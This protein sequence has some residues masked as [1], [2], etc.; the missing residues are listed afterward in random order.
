MVPTFALADHTTPILHPQIL[1]RPCPK[2]R[3][4]TE[5]QEDQE[6]SFS[7][8]TGQADHTTLSSNTLR[9]RSARSALWGG[10]DRGEMTPSGQGRH[11]PTLDPSGGSLAAGPSAPGA[12]FSPGARGTR[13]TNFTPARP[14]G[15]VSP[16]GLCCLLC[17]Q[18]QE[19]QG[20]SISLDGENCNCQS[21]ADSGAFLR[22]QSGPPH[23]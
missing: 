7:S 21:P 9:S 16:G 4:L 11:P 14:A 6:A 17:Q 15:P 1:Q 23:S 3:A 8:L 18:G 12:P 2:V 20:S 10:A 5:G 19:G 13:G 22:P